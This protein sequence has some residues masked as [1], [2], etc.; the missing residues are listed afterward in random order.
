[1]YVLTIHNGTSGLRLIIHERNKEKGQ[2]FALGE[3]TVGL[4]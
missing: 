4:K 3:G 2:L 1:M